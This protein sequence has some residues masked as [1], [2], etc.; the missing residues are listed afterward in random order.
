M[1]LKSDSTPCTL[2]GFMIIMCR[3]GIGVHRDALRRRLQLLQRVDQAVGVPAISAP[4]R[5]APN[6]RDREIAPG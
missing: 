1:V 6:S 5:S 4:P 2:N 3:G